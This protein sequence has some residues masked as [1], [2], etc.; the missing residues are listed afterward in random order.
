MQTHTSMQPD[1]NQIEWV[2]CSASRQERKEILVNV[3][4]L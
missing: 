3:S 4:D 2:S 1:E